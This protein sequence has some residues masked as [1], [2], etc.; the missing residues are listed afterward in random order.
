MKL[1]EWV[2]EKIPIKSIKADE[3]GNLQET[4]EWHTQKTIY[5]DPPAIKI[6]CK[7][8]DH[9]W[10]VVDTHNHI[11]ACKHCKRRVK[12]YPVTHDY[13]DGQLIHRQTKQLV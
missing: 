10:Y 9:Y 11:F 6:V 3:K 7:T 13:K 8:G 4:T 12:V 5:I 1:N 2:E